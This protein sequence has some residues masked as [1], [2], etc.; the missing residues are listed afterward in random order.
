MSIEEVRRLF[1]AVSNLKHRC[2][3]KIVYGGGLRLGE[4]VNLRLSDIRSDWLQVF[5][6]DGKG[7]KDRYTTLSATF[8]EELRGYFQEYCPQHWLFEGQSGGQYSKRSVQAILR[9][10]VD[11]SKVNPLCMVHTLRHSYATHLLESG[12]SLRHIQE[13]LGQ[14]DSKTTER[15]TH[16]STA[17]K[18]RITSPL[19]RI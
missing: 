3:L 5:I 10:A 2:I 12:V 4:V 7:K 19:D 18:Q 8:L 11:K 17:E 9:K 16:V 13:L 14:A 15:Y 1:A 6:N